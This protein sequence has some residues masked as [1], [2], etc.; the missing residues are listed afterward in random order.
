MLAVFKH[1]GKQQV[2]HGLDCFQS[3][4]FILLDGK[5]MI[6]FTIFRGKIHLILEVTHLW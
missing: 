2:G 1:P 6:T 3:L 4:F 5:L